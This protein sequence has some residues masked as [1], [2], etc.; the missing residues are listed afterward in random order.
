MSCPPKLGG[1]AQ[2]FIGELRGKVAI[3]NQRP[4]FVPFVFIWRNHASQANQ[5]RFRPKIHD[6]RPRVPAKSAKTTPALTV[7]AAAP[8]ENVSAAVEQLKTPAVS[9]NTVK[10]EP[11]VSVQ[12]LIQALRD[13]SADVARDAAVELGLPKIARLSAHSSK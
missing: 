13:P 1:A 4:I 11:V 9:C 3:T 10:M 6:P 8:K 12:S 5:D 7:A 2:R